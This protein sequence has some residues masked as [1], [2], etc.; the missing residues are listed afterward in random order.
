MEA[1]GWGGGGGADTRS[2]QGANVLASR[3]SRQQPGLRPRRQLA[4][5]P[6]AQPLCEEVP[7]DTVRAPTLNC[8][9]ELLGDRRGQGPGA[10]LPW[11]RDLLPQPEVSGPLCGQSLAN[12]VSKFR[13]QLHSFIRSLI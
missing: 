9:R 12:S 5:I 1:R 4:R 10:G 8:A 11:G 2:P 6:A 7:E 13:N 3:C